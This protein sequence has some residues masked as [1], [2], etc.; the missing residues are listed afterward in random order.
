MNDA[1]MPGQMCRARGRGY[2]E[3]GPILERGSAPINSV[4][5]PFVC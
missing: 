5:Q 2:A 1:A 3:A 4:D